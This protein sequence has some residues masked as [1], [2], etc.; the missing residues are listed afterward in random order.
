MTNVDRI[1]A[2]A[3]KLT[4]EEFVELRARLF[5]AEAREEMAPD[6]KAAWEEEVERRKRMLEA[7]ETTTRPWDE[8]RA[9]FLSLGK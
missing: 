4:E 3:K 7:G 6:I 2:E 1:L 5:E 8:V 9:D